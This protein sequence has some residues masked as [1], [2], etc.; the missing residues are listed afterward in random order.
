M[1]RN[2]V[3]PETD[4]RGVEKH[5]AFC[6]ISASRITSNPG[7]VL[8]QS[9]IR[10]QNTVRVRIARAD[11]RRDL[12]HDWVHDGQQLIEVEMSEA[13]WASFVSSMNT[14]GVPATLRSTDTEWDIPDLPYAPR[15][16]ESMA[17]VRGK[18]GK[19]FEQVKDALDEYETVLDNKAGVKERRAALNKL[20]YT[21]HNSESNVSFAAKSLSEHAENVVQKARADI[22]AMVSQEATK[23]GI[24]S[25]NHKILELPRFGEDGAVS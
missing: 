5:P 7:A 8:F 2:I 17:E 22:E 11:R 4:E 13:Q 12:H 25:G 24:K 14:S 9:D 1:V 3:E 20:H 15:L 16:A 19:L 6:M 23:L 10:H 18:A 21:I